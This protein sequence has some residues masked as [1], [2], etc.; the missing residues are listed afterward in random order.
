MKL[1]QKH[2]PKGRR[3]IFKIS[4][5]IVPED[6]GP[7]V[8]A[9]TRTVYKDIPYFD[10]WNIGNR[11]TLYITLLENQSQSKMEEMANRICK[12]LSI[13]WRTYQEKYQIHPEIATGDVIEISDANSEEYT[14]GNCYD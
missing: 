7:I 2:K 9:F 12:G 8:P 3:S 4:F 10:G 1:S 5:A 13:Y 6:A 14:T 11:R